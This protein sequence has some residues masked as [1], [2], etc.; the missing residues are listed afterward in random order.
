MPEVAAMPVAG[1]ITRT[2]IVK[3][4]MPAIHSQVCWAGLEIPCYS[5]GGLTSRVPRSMEMQFGTF[6]CCRQKQP[7]KKKDV[8]VL[9]GSK[10]NKADQLLCQRYQIEPTV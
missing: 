8:S 4:V 6:F 10:R 1:L 5:R 2:A 7:Q 9:P 3:R